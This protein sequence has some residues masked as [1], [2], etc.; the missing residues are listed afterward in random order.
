[1]KRLTI[2]L[3]LGLPA[4]AAIGQTNDLEILMRQASDLDAYRNAMYL[5]L[6]LSGL[7]WI[8]VESIAAVILWRAYFVLRRAVRRKGLLPD[9]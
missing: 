5:L 7:A 4:C 6:R 2:C 1:M 3:F 8:A 9:A